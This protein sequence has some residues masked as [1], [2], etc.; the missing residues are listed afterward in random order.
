MKRLF[1]YIL[2]V[3]AIIG[4][5][6]IL[7]RSYKAGLNFCNYEMNGRIDSIKIEEKG[8]YSISINNEW[9]YIGP[10]ALYEVYKISI[11]DSISKKKDCYKVYLKRNGLTYDLSIDGKLPC[12]CN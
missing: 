6:I 7:F 5:S 8:Y 10:Y 3:V 2:G 1:Q 9:Y 12:N 11:G 4:V